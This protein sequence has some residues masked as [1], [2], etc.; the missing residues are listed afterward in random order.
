MEPSITESR[1]WKPDIVHFLNESNVWNWLLA[2]L[3]RT[4]PIITTVHDVGFHLGDKGSRRVPRVFATTLIRQT[5]AV[6][7]HGHALCAAAVKE[8]PIRADQVYVMPLVSPLIPN[9]GSEPVK[10]ARPTT[11]FSGFF[12]FGRILEYKGLP[13][14]LKAMRLVNEHMKN[15]RLII[16]GQGD[17]ISLY[18]DLLSGASYLDIRNQFILELRSNNSL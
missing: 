7:V 13:Y 12:F 9:S 18:P 3:L 2:Y 10:Q 14:L 1:D 8:L 17:D 5:D 6:I 4:S 11:A 16:A 15:V